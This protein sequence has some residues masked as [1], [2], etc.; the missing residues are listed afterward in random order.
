MSRIDEQND[1]ELGSTRM[2]GCVLLLALIVASVVAVA[3]LCMACGLGG[4]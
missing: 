2:L 3:A 1:D 4:L